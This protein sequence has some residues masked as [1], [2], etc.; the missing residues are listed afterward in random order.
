MLVEGRLIAGPT[1][2]IKPG[3]EGEKKNEVKNVAD[4]ERRIATLDQ[5]RLADE[6]DDH[7]R[8]EIPVLVQRKRHHRL[9]VQDEPRRLIRPD[10]LFPVELKRHADQ[11]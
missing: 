4:T 9:N 6:R 7:S 10:V 8:D 11:V 5:S 3:R 1:P 2:H